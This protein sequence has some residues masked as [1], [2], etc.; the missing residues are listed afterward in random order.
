M[1]RL[2]AMRRPQHVAPFFFTGHTKF[3]FIRVIEWK[4]RENIHLF[5]KRGCILSVPCGLNLSIEQ[6]CAL[7]A[8]KRHRRL[9]VGWSSLLYALVLTK[10]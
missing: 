10:W 4:I 7:A 6:S 2:C 5:G 3:K 9:T 8:A 1:R